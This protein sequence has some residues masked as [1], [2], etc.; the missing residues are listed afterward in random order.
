MYLFLAQL[1]FKNLEEKSFDG[2]QI[3]IEVGDITIPAG[4][5]FSGTDSVRVN[6]RA[7]RCRQHCKSFSKRADQLYYTL[8]IERHRG[9][10]ARDNM[11]YYSRYNPEWQRI[12]MYAVA[13]A[14]QDIRFADIAA[15]FQWQKD[16]QILVE[17]SRKFDPL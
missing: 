10:F 5:V 8:R 12:E 17:I 11:R 6:R 7:A 16:E 15:A 2:F 14:R 13:R 3:G 4:A 1:I 9:N